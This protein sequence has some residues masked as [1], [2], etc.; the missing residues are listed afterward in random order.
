MKNKIALALLL[1]PLVTICSNQ[2]PL[3]DGCETT[4]FNFLRSFRGR[5]YHAALNELGSFNHGS[6][7]DQARFFC[8]SDRAQKAQTEEELK[9]LITRKATMVGVKKCMSMFGDPET[10]AGKSLCMRLFNVYLKT[11]KTH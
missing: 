7:A 9:A 11:R 1:M 5:G 3:K 8:N 2:L 6:P 10:E 4:I